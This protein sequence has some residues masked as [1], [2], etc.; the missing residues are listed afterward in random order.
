MPGER[1][2]VVR[3]GKTRVVTATRIEA[4]PGLDAGVRFP[5]PPEGAALDLSD[6]SDAGP[7][8]ALAT[9]PSGQPGIRLGR[10]GEP[11]GP[12]AMAMAVGAGSAL[13]VDLDPRRPVAHVWAAGGAGEAATDEVRLSWLR[14][15][16]PARV[17]VSWGVFDGTL[18]GL[19]ARSLI[20]P[21]GER[22]LRLALGEG[23]AAVLSRGDEVLATSWH[24]G[25]PFQELLADDG[26][27]THLTLLHLREGA[28]PFSLEILE[29]REE[30]ALRTG[31]PVERLLDRA[32]ALR[33]S[34]PRAVT[35]LSDENAVQPGEP[36]TLHL[37]GAD[38]EAVVLSRHGDVTRGTDLPL[39]DGGS[40]LVRHGTGFFLAWVEQVGMGDA[41]LWR[42]FGGLTARREP[43]FR[44]P[45]SGDFASFTIPPAGPRVLHVRT[46]APVAT[47]LRRLSEDNDG[48]S[49]EIRVHPDGGRLDAFLPG[50]EAQLG[51]RALAGADLFGT[52]EVTTTPVTPIGEG[53]GPAV[54]LPAG[55]TRWFSFHLEKKGP[56]GAG[57][58]STDDRADLDLY[59]RAGQRLAGGEGSVVRMLDLE[60][61]DY[62]LAVR[63]PA[64]GPPVTAR[65]A[66][67]GVKPPD[68]GPPEDVVRQY[69]QQAAE[70]ES[71][72]GETENE[73]ET[74]TDSDETAAPESGS[75]RE[76]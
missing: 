16:E 24:G 38:A 29:A 52:A 71:L 44:V 56:V 74:E 68:T 72:P 27:A 10:R 65:P 63:A 62:L 23:M 9:S 25:A 18:D 17:A 48:G 33:L 15:P 73:T 40:V 6:P 5:L 37:R 47:L 7:L 21:A 59:D 66:L 30:L 19:A 42:D 20:L 60:P 49:P 14:L 3:E 67:A 64:D 8:I 50:G 57:V 35:A 69:L 70:E 41:A 31:Q 45:L 55:A 39:P 1:A 58:R 11:G 34:I 51:L 76:S 43:P 22:T 61:G 53:L 36:R 46:D 4:P 26:A 28:D 54:L 32:G 12:N 13:A 75:G 2:W